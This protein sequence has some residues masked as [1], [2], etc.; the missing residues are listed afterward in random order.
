MSNLRELFLNAEGEVDQE[1]KEALLPKEFAPAKET[2][3]S[4]YPRG[5]LPAVRLRAAGV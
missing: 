5:S 2:I 4:Q 1:L 3:V